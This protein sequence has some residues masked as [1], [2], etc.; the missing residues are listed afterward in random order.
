MQNGFQ[1][2]S[3]CTTGAQVLQSANRL[4]SGILVCGYRFVDMMCTELQEY[5]PTHFEMLLVASPTNCEELSIQNI[6]CL[7]TP[8]KVHELLQTVEMMDYTIARKRKK[9]K[10]KPKERSDEEMQLIE[11][12]KTLLMNRNNL[13]EEEAHRYMQKRSMDNGTGLAETAQMILSLLTS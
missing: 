10:A 13:S 7:A 11:E 12:A 1:V 3:T 9:E 6:V 5:L 4:D 8:L 2:E